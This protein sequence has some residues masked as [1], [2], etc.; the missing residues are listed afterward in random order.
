MGREIRKVPGDWAHP[1]Y[2]HDQVLYNHQVDAF[3]PLYDEDYDSSCA[4]WYADAAAY[5]PMG[6]CQWF[7]DYN[8]GPP[9][10]DYYR[11]R[12]WTD[13]EATHFVVYETVS[14]GTP[15]TPAF[16]T[17]E[18]LVDYLVANGDFWD[19]A[20]GDGGWEREAAERFVS[21]GWAPSM[22]VSSAGVKTARDMV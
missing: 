5:K 19:Q 3:H 13:E 6:N 21:L 2:E 9:N 17:K 7:H 22:I 1:K 4:R 16:P 8:G 18:Q 14:E 20:R 12:K 10:K 11:D 15:V